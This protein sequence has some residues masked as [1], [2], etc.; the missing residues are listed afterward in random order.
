MTIASR[1]HFLPSVVVLGIC[2]VAHAGADPISLRVVKQ[3]LIEGYPAGT[4]LKDA[5]SGE[6]KAASFESS[7]AATDGTSVWII[8]DKGAPGNVLSNVVK[9]SLATLKEK[10]VVPFADVQPVKA[11]VFLKMQKIESTAVAEGG[12]RFASTAFDRFKPASNELDAFNVIVAWHGTDFDKAA[13][14]NPLTLD[15]VTS[16]ISLRKPLRAALS[17]DQWPKGPP[18]IKVEGLAALPRKRLWFGI[19]ESGKDGESPAGFAYRFTV[20]ETTW[21]EKDGH[22]AIVPEF[23]KVFEATPDQLAAAGV[24][25][26]AGLSGLSSLEYDPHRGIVWAVASWEEG[27]NDGASLLALTNPAAGEA[28]KLLPVRGADGAPLSFSHKVEGLCVVND[29]TLLLVSDEDRRA[30]VIQTP[31]GPKKREPN[32]GVFTILETAPQ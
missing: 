9:V 24:S 14:L 16:S 15:G 20:L 21:E 22:T 30:P 5:K 12:L 18:Y 4:K 10:A 32:M 7:A 1:F 13:V 2:L 11:P 17:E 8:G 28:P 31:D 25:G 23:R 29:H 19:R 27:D 3:G 26:K 6:E